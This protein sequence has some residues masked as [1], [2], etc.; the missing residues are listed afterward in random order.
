M[1]EQ[2][3]ERSSNLERPW[4]LTYR[5]VLFPSWQQKMSTGEVLLKSCC[6]FYAGK[7]MPKHSVQKKFEYG[8]QMAQGSFWIA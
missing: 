6:G 8:R 2:E 5:Q 3:L 1:I 4:D 7:L